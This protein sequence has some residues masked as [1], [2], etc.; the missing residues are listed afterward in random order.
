M[1]RGERSTL[2]MDDEPQPST[3]A[4]SSA[5]ERLVVP[6]LEDNPHSGKSAVQDRNDEEV[7]LQCHQRGDGS[8]YTPL[9]LV[10]DKEI[11]LPTSSM[12]TSLPM[13]TPEEEDEVLENIEDNIPTEKIPEP[14]TFTELQ[15][16]TI[17]PTDPAF[18]ANKRLSAEII[19]EA[20]KLEL[21]DLSI[22]D[23]PSSS[24]RKFNPKVKK[25]LLPNG[26][27]KDRKWLVNSRHDMMLYFVCIV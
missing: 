12:E 18:Y 17:D 27:T 15:F 19:N 9:I 3:S 7:E 13:S 11:E 22:I 20:L 24:G 2:T 16:S 1:G 6:G 26:T 14:I 21:Q 5:I 25:S 8:K 23:F 10:H 4:Q